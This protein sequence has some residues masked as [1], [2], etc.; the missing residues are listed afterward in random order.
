MIIIDVHNHYLPEKIA[1]A[2]GAEP[3]KPVT[4]MEN[5][6]PKRM[7]SDREY[8]I[9]ERLRAMDKAGISIQLLSVPVGWNAPPDECRY[10]NDCLSDTQALYPQRLKGLASIPIGHAETEVISEIHRAIGQLR[11]KGIS[12]SAQPGGLYLDDQRLWP[13]YKEIEKMKAGVFIHPSPLPPGFKALEGYDFLRVIGRE[14]DLVTAVCRVIYGKVLDTFPDLK[15]VFSHFGGGLA[16]LLE[17][18]D[19]KYKP[20]Y[21]LRQL[22]RDFGEYLERLYFDTAG[23]AGGMR[24]F[25]AGF[26]VFGADHLLF[27]SDYPQDFI[28]GEQIKTYVDNVNSYLSSD[29]NRKIMGENAIRIFQLE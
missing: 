18:V 26:E 8:I 11:L 17:R 4:V 7:V 15:L 19:P 27:G 10:V 14:F 1:R 20:W 16:N 3:G 12:I 25:R 28:E 22:P 23:F 29:D 9:D 2:Y 13:I 6:V 24:A 21:K 5:G